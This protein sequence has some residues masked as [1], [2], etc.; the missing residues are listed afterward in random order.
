MQDIR[1]AAD[2]KGQRPPGTKPDDLLSEAREAMWISPDQ[3]TAEGRWFWGE[4][5]EF[6]FEVKLV[7][8]SIEP[9][10]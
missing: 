8:A 4:Y 7:R 3:S 10:D 5:Q 6:G 9:D 2:P 1:G